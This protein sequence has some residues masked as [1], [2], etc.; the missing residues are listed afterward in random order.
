[1]KKAL[2]LSSLMFIG[3]V[4]FQT[5]C[6]KVDEILALIPPD[7]S[8]NWQLTSATLVDPDPLIVAN[9]PLAGLPDAPI[10]AGAATV[11]IVTGLV[12]GALAGVACEN[13]ANYTGF[14]L[15]LASGGILK[16]HCPAENVADD[17]G[18]WTLIL[19][20]DGAYTILT[21]SVNL[22]GIPFPVQITVNDFALSSDGNT[23]TGRA[24]GY[25]MVNDLALPISATGNA[26]FITTDMVF[27]QLP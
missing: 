21:L 5:S 13:P 16:F 25:P 7:V 18:T 15:E 20:A 26:Q 12:G 27:T 23:F 4:L 8:G 19:D 9:L 10:A 14:Y 1:M 11:Q 24:S 3:L 17:A 2:K 6:N 22:E